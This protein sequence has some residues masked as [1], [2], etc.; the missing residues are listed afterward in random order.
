MK[1]LT[2]KV[3]RQNKKTYVKILLEVEETQ[4]KSKDEMQARLNKTLPWMAEH[5]VEWADFDYGYTIDLFVDSLTH[6]GKGLL[7]WDNCTNSLRN[8]RRALTAAKMLHNA[9]NYATWDDKSYINWSARNTTTWTKIKGGVMEGTLMKNECVFS[10]AMGVEAQEY[11][12]RMWRI[13]YK[14]QTEAEEAL[15]KEAW[16]YIAKYIV[17]LWD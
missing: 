12:D 13:I 16:E 4:W 3:Y 11:S 14:R 9:Y 8:G 6:L 2:S 15:K 5:L 7:S 1:I 10:N 17:Y